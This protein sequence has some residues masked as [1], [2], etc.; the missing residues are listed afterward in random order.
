MT[1]RDDTDAERAAASTRALESIV[2][3]TRQLLAS[4]R[5][6][7]AVADFV[8]GTPVRRVSPASRGIPNHSILRGP[9]TSPE[10]TEAMRY[11]S[12]AL[13][14]WAARRRGLLLVLSGPAYCG[15]SVA[16]AHAV[17]RSEQPARYVFAEDLAAIGESTFSEVQRERDAVRSVP[18][19]S[20]DEAWRERGRDARERI[21]AVMQRRYN[22]GRATLIA[23]NLSIEAFTER[24]LIDPH[25]ELSGAMEARLNQQEDD[26]CRWFELIEPLDLGAL[27][28][29]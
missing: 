26:G 25:G 24:Y 10:P 13:E 6:Q 11:V 3:R 28:R 7:D 20:I 16:L 1:V 19:L 2:G 15:K 14:W 4:Q 23:T 8:K 5:H 21:A 12:R 27:T 22:D 17:L 29:R 9:A 18:L